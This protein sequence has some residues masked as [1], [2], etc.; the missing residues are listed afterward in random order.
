MVINPKNDTSLVEAPTFVIASIERKAPLSFAQ[1]RLWFLDQLVPNS[2]FYNLAGAVRLDGRLDLEVLDSVINEIVRRHETLRTRFEVEEGEPVQVIDEWKPRRLEVED[3]TMLPREVREAEARRITR[4]ESETGFELDLGPLLRVK[5]LRLEEERHMALFNM[6]HIVGDAWSMGLLVREVA[7]LYEA[8]SRGQRSPLPELEI[9][10]ADYAVWQREHLG[11]VAL[12]REVGYWKERLK[13]AAVLD[14]PADHT[15]PAVST[16]RGARERVEIDKKLSD[17]LRRLSQREGASLFMALMAAF[18]ALLMRYSGEEDISVGTAITNRTRRGVEGLIGFFVNTLVMR[19]DLSGNPSFRELVRRERKVALEAYAHQEAPFEKVVEEI[20]PER[21]LSRSPLFAV[22][23]VLEDARGK[24]LEIKGLKAQWAGEDAA[25]AKFDLELVLTQ[26][27]EGT[28]GSLEYSCDLYE[29][30][31]IRRMARHFE[32]V[33]AEVVRDPDQRIKDID[34][35]RG[36]EREQILVEW[37]QT[38][39][40][41]PRDRSIHELFEEQAESRPDAVAVAYRDQELSYRELNARANHLAGTLLDLGVGPEVV[42]ALLSERGIDFLTAM[43][44]V[45]KAGGAYLPLDPRHPARR[46][47][48]ALGQSG[49]SLVLTT[50]KFGSPAAEAVAGLA[51]EDRPAVLF[52]DDL[53]KEPGHEENPGRP[54][55]PNQLAYVIFT[56]GSTGAPKGAMVEHR[57]M[58]NH[59]LAKVRTLWLDDRDVVAQTASQCFDISVWQFLAALL[60]GGRVEVFDDEVAHDPASLLDQVSLRKVSIL[61]IVPSMLR[62]ILTEGD[63]RLAEGNSKPELWSLR[64]LIPTGEA[65]APGVCHHWFSLYPEIPL[66]NAYGPTECSDD[67]THCPVNEVLSESAAR[68]PIGRPIANTQ[69]YVLDGDLRPQPVGVVGELYVGGECV[70]RGYL[71]EAGKTSEYFVPAPFATEIGARLYKSGDLARYLPDGNLEYLGRIDHQVKI[72]G[73]RIEPGEI[74]AAIRRH[75]SIAPLI[76]EAVVVAREDTPGEKRL[77]AYL[78]AKPETALSV[79]DLRDFLKQELPEYMSPAAYVALSAL[80]LTE[81]GKLDRHALPAPEAGSESEQGYVAPH[82]LV[83]QRLAE[84]WSQVLGVDRVGVYSDFF[85]MGGHSL[86]ATQV[87]SRTRSAFQVEL[88]LRALFEHPTVSE[89]GR[90]VEQAIEVG[91]GAQA[92]PLVRAPRDSRRLPLSFAQQRLWL[93]EQLEPGA[94]TYNITG[95]VRLQGTLDLDALESAINEIVRRHEALRTRFEVE[96][97][98]PLQVI[99]HWQPRKLGV[100]KLTGLPREKREEEARKVLKEEAAKGFD[101]SRGPLFRVKVLELGEDERLVF[102]NM[103]HIVSDGWSMGILIAEVNRLYDAYA[104]GEETPL[105]ELAIQYSDYAMWQREW[106]QGA[107]LER[108]LAYWK[109]QLAGVPSLLQLPTDRPRTAVEAYRGAYERFELSREL[110]NKLRRLS[111]SEGATLFMTLLAGFQ[112][113]LARYSGEARIAVGVPVAGRNREE[114]EEVIGLFINTLVMVADVSGNPTARQFL[115]QVRETTIGAFAHQD[116]PFEK[117]VEELQPERGLGQPLFQVMFAFQNFLKG[118]LAISNLKVK[119][120]RVEVDGAKFELDL[121]IEEEGDRVIGSIEYARDLYEKESIILLSGHLTRLLERMV[122]DPECRVLD[123]TLL[124]DR[125]WEQV[126]EWNRTAVRHEKEECLHASFEEQARRAPDRVAGVDEMGAIS[127]GELNRRAN[128]LGNHLRRRGVGPEARVGICLER[129][130][131][132]LVGLLGILKAG[133]AYAPLDPRY[134]AERLNFM[135]DDAA[136]Q[137]IVTQKKL[138]ELLESTKAELIF[139]D[140]DPGAVVREREENI[141]SGVTSEN[142]AYVIYTS[143]STGLPKGAMITH[144][145]VVN[146]V[147][148][149][150]GK[151]RLERDSKFFQFASLSF[152]V[153]VEEIFPVLS[154]G[155]AVVM[156]SDDLLYS[157]SD[158]A[159]TVERH[160]V[161]TIELPTVYW[162]E[163]MRELSRMRRRAP[164]SLNLVIIGGE[165]ISPEILKEWRE[166]EVPLLHVYGVT[167][168]AVTS[169]VHPI[170]ADHTNFGDESGLLEI[171]IGR[172]MAGTEAYLLDDRLQPTPLRIP[173]EMYLGGVGLA[174][175]Y[176]NRPD[177][178]AER[179]VPSPFGMLPG[180]RLYRTGDLARS[181]PDG[182]MEFI[183]R[184]DRQIKIRGHRIEPVEI[185]SVLL[186]LPPVSECA[187]IARGDGPDDRRLVA[188]LVLKEGAAETALGLRRFASQRLPAYLVPSSFVILQSLPLTPHGKVDRQALPPPGVYDVELGGEYVAPATPL[189][190]DV[191]GIFGDAL[192]IDDVGIY[193]DF[194]A[195][196]GH[197]FL[198]PRVVSRV[199]SA[200]RIELPIRA[201]FDAPTVSGI[202]AAIVESQAEQLEDDVLS[203]MLAEL[204]TLSDEEADAAFNN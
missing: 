25:T 187:V 125:E 97:G 195:L 167:E 185:E 9:Q 39:I 166:H 105:E 129:G 70:G 102:F 104:R 11:G 204:E 194:F 79:S 198:A 202:V 40:N 126:L 201:L 132:M 74:E 152:D 181:S 32:K 20:N 66:L 94:A 6:H 67:V 57:G 183:G 123:V 85:D 171:P 135:L 168:V 190:E 136:V 128:Q 65:L 15:R 54:F 58:L 101:L 176:L 159:K 170:P 160:E 112:M 46:L 124:T 22:M 44:A 61:E 131:S 31:T 86:L 107:V 145:S 142:L 186:Q 80:P 82:T 43:L 75:P 111:R 59:L 200:F 103:H 127:Y 77:V 179:F 165:R 76:A 158:L 137:L 91:R 50:S 56:S 140:G 193:D 19:T 153:A 133:G 49:A 199:N 98:A 12:E 30:E 155:G 51:A 8:M 120:E 84:I 87:I 177:L 52:M 147:S 203:Q 96:D 63:R 26:S 164:R 151:F 92:P 118:P 89:L 174:R 141:D 175:G 134:P 157:Y 178:T 122:D 93:I 99:D 48:Q 29:G 184:I 2:P 146:L 68:T 148:D 33:V 188:Y 45:F 28:E 143:G 18:K 130:I 71:N 23:M 110:A 163:W 53:F 47:G 21:N 113:L 3:L 27:G 37:N 41:Y 161:T 1:Q 13:G 14:L 197:S 108:Q 69:I 88:P 162:V 38:A 34:L 73:F 182:C 115:R 189:E 4:E 169:I 106:M 119:E 81:N 78:V 90:K 24:D 114:T 144:R 60:V 154:V 62:M 139:I 42:V 7:L 191:A 150:R 156:Q 192:G 95:A 116:L 138:R 109:R 100:E 55:L 64:W 117:L 10:Y 149:A 172:P 83:E 180:S 35:M 121:T 173:S 196:G 72:R 5:V 17:G 16:Y 36:S